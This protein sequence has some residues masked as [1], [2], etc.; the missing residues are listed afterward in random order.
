MLFTDIEGS[1]R[2]LQQLGRERYSEAL[3]LHRRV[4]RSAFDRH[5]GYEVD[6]EGDAFFVAFQSAERAVLAAEEAQQ[7]LAAADWPQNLTLSV[8]MGIHTGE[9]LVTPPKYVGLDVHRAARMMAAAHGGQVLLSQSTRDLVGGDRMRDLGEHRLKDLT[10]PERIYQLGD[11]DFPPVRSLD[12]TNL[13]VA[14]SPLIG[15]ARELAELVTLIRNGSRLITMTG[16]GGSGKTRLALQ[17]AAEVVDDFPGG[18]FFVPLAPLRDP[19]LFLSSVA[20]AMQT[21]ETGD[22]VERLRAARALLVL[23]NFEHLLDAAPSVAELLAN[24]PPTKALATSRAPLRISGER[25]YELDPFAYDEAV[26]FFLARARDVRDD[27]QADQAVAAIC[28]RLDRLPLALELAAAR[29]RLLDPPTLLDRLEQRLPLLTAGQRDAPERQ[30][31]LRA[32]IDWSYELLPAPAQPLFCRLAVFAGT[33]SLDAAE[34]IAGA[35]IDSLAALADLSLLKPMPTGRFLLL[36]TIREYAAERLRERGQLEEFQRRHASYFAEVAKDLNVWIRPQ[37]DQ[38]DEG[39]RFAIFE[40]EQ[41]NLRV[42][43]DSMLRLGMTDVALEVVFSLSDY[44]LTRAQLEEGERWNELALAAAPR[45]PSLAIA[46]TISGVGEFARFRGD[47]RRAIDLKEQALEMY[48]SFGEPVYVAA[49]LHDLADTWAHIGEYERA[50]ELS[51][52]ALEIRRQRGSPYGI[53]H[54]LSSLADIELFEHNYD[55]AERLYEEILS[56]ERR[57]R[58]RQADTM[59]ALGSLAECL[60]RKGDVDRARSLVSEAIEIARKMNVRFGVGEVLTSAAALL[61]AEA[62]SLAATLIGASDAVRSETTFD[63]WDPEEDKRIKETV[64]AALGAS[65]YAM[66]RAEGEKFPVDT[67]LAQAQSALSTAPGARHLE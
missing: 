35:D 13:P 42:A 54:A 32:T 55:E 31:T 52:E 39:E 62:P 49:T 33:F 16:A 7:A 34:R 26:E 56:I 60:R 67:A 11:R 36:E 5:S 43:L 37:L 1:T 64:Q 63:P 14:A 46:N 50:R 59:V 10:A 19:A 44:W 3:E 20:G 53:A 2:L 61:A 25:E 57:N 22:L 58:H 8:R 40:R 9:P 45:M 65:T 30:K 15:R 6:C 27:V 18:V 66:R 28:Q 38:D 23:D 24:A 51:L 17:A 41:D 47:S 4:L 21:K 29:V 48:R 12:R